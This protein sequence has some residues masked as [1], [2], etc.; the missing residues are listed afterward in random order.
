MA[1]TTQQRLSASQAVSTSA[2]G[3][4]TDTN[5]VRNIL[6]AYISENL[7]GSGGT[8]GSITGTLS[9]QTDLQ[10]ALDAKSSMAFTI[11]AACGG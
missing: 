2:F 1:I 11:L 7:S 9:S 5:S 8:W 3:A 10:A 4:P 6:L